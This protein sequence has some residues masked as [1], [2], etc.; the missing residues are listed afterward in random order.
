VSVAI[1]S[2]GDA[3]SSELGGKL[4]MFVFVGAVA[5]V[6]GIIAYSIQK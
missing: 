1:S 2:S 5:V 4:M 6:I 3:S